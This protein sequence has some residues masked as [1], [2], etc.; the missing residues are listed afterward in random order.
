MNG[1]KELERKSAS[2]KV[3]EY[4][5]YPKE[6][7]NIIYNLGGGE[8]IF[9][10]GEV[11]KLESHK[12]DINKKNYYLKSAVWTYLQKLEQAGKI[13]MKGRGIDGI[14]E[15]IRREYHKTEL[16]SV[17]GASK[18]VEPICVI[19]AGNNYTDN[20]VKALEDN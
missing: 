4:V 14:D 17:P 20:V 2:E 12:T 10:K 15:I 9:L 1:F 18:R 11:K 16:S 8:N 5:F 6:V 13:N 7:R 3:G 19:G